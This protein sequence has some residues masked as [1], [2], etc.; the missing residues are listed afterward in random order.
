M[1]GVCLTV[2]YSLRQK[3]EEK[4]ALSIKQDTTR[5]KRLSIAQR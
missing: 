5:L 2:C 4:Q 3:K 1:N